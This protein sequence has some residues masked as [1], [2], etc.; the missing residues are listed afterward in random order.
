MFQLTEM[1]FLFDRYGGMN[2]LLPGNFVARVEYFRR[3]RYGESECA[4]FLNSDDSLG[5]YV[6]CTLER[7]LHNG[8]FSFIHE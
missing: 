1:P 3:F 4:L 5:I 8:R 6:V 7:G 2:S